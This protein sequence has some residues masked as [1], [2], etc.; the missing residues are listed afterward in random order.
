VPARILVQAFLGKKSVGNQQQSLVQLKQLQNE[1]DACC[2]AAESGPLAAVAWQA[3][4]IG[5][6]PLSAK[7]AAIHPKG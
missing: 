1:R 2:I 3:A 4:L 5:L 6:L 7:T